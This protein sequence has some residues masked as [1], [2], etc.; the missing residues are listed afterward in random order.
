M[1]SS[2]LQRA[3]LMA[4]IDHERHQHDQPGTCHQAHG[5]MVGKG[6]GAALLLRHDCASSAVHWAVSTICLSRLL[7]DSS[8]R[9]GLRLDLGCRPTRQLV[10]TLVQRV[11]RVT[12]HIAKRNAMLVAQRNQPLPQIDVLDAIFQRVAGMKATQPME[13]ADHEQEVSNWV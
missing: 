13:E 5:G 9:S 6:S 7:T 8:G 1:C 11:T 10:A 12:G 3:R 2:D 4:I